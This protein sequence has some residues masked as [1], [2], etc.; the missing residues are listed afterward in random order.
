MMPSLAVLTSAKSSSQQRSALTHLFLPHVCT[1]THAN[2]FECAQILAEDWLQGAR[3]PDE[4]HGAW[5]HW[6]TCVL[7]RHLARSGLTCVR[8]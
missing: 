1:S 5:P 7:L 4:P 6:R 3:T 2:M 8:A